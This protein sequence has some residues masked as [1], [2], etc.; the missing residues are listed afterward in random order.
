MEIVP[1]VYGVDFDG[2]AWA[3]LY[4]HGPRFTLIDCGLAGRLEVLELKLKGLGAHFSDIEQLVLTHCHLDHVGTASE[5]QRL[6]NVPTMVHQLDAPIVRGEAVVAE[7]QLS[8]WERQLHE[9]IAGN[10]LP[11]PLAHVDRELADGDV[12]K[13][14]H[15]ATV[16]HVPGHT[17]GSVAL[18]VATR[19]LLF[20]GD[21]AASVGTRPIVGVFNVDPERARESFRKMAALEPESVCFGH[22]PPLSDGAAGPM[23]KTAAAL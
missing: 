2:L 19:R 22:G 20:T 14:G 7:P 1:G 15:D 17:D 13:M 9:R 5:L 16:V 23:R 21:A 11:A 18:Y 8:D 4:R 6:T 3:Y 10:M 12:I